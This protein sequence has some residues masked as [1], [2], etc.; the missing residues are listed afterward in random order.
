MKCTIRKGLGTNIDVNLAL[1]QI[2]SSPIDAGQPSA[3]TLL[4]NR[5]I[6]GLLLQMNSTYKHDNAQYKAL[7]AHQN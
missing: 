1:P 6:R 5:P 2:Q 3:P 4:F 7:K